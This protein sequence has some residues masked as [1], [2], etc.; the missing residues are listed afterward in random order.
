MRVVGAGRTWIGLRSS[1]GVEKVRRADMLAMFHERA[2][3]ES[4]RK[5]G[6]V[7]DRHGLKS[8]GRKTSRE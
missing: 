8:E 1:Y 4:R 5:D 3:Q 7:E 2:C 6:W